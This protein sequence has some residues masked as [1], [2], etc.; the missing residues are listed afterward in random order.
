MKFVLDKSLVYWVKMNISNEL[1]TKY[2]IDLEGAVKDLIEGGNWAELLDLTAR[3]RN[4]S[5][6]NLLL[7]FSQASRRGFAPTIVA[8]YRS[9]QKLG[10]QVVRGEKALYIF[11]PRLKK[12]EKQRII[13]TED[14]VSI[15]EP[16]ALVGYRLVAVFDLSQTEGANLP[17]IPEP[18]LLSKGGAE[19]TEIISRI[20]IALEARGFQVSFELLDSVN[21]YTDF[22]NRVVKVRSD[23]QPAQKLKTMI[24]ETAHVMLHERSG[25]SRMQA[26]LEAESC[27]YVVCRALGIDSSSY[28][29][30][31][32]ARWCQ[33]DMDLVKAVTK[34]IHLATNEILQELGV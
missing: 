21:G 32:I 12:S 27:A 6:L 7:I 20:Q 9:W 26:E 25:V 13:E 29:F 31:Y 17:E 5:T 1:I 15:D 34:N 4:Y 19:V 22:G 23:V 2:G 33:G 30:P 28:S 16:N 10:R 8:G 24:H 3:F 18:S 11:A 14:H